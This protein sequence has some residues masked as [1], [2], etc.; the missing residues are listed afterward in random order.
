MKAKRARFFLKTERA[1]SRLGKIFN[2]AVSLCAA[3]MGAPNKKERSSEANVIV[4]PLGV[5]AKVL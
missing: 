4:L 3:N 5:A 1:V 2:L